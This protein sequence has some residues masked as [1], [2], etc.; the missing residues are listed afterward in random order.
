[1]TTNYEDAPLE[2]FSG[3]SV[4]ALYYAVLY[5]GDGPNVCSS[6]PLTWETA[7]EFNYGPMD[8][9][10]AGWYGMY[11]TLTHQVMQLEASIGK[12]QESW[13][14]Q[15]SQVYFDEANKA[16]ESMKEAQEKALG[17]ARAW[18]ELSSAAAFAYYGVVGQK[19]A[20]D[21]HRKNKQDE[22]DQ[23]KKDDDWY[24]PFDGADEPDWDEERAPF[25]E[26]ARRAVSYGSR[27]ISRIYVEDVWAPASYTPPPDPGGDSSIP[28]PGG[29]NDGGSGTPGSPGYPGGPGAPGYP[30]GPPSGTLPP[31]GSGPDLQGPIP[32]PMPPPNFP[33]PTLPTPTPTPTP[34][35]PPTLPPPTVPPPGLPKPPPGLPKPPPSL[36]KPPPVTPKPPPGLPRPT[37]TP[38]P[39]PKPPPNL[40]KPPPPSTGPTPRPPGRTVPPVI[41]PRP[42]GPGFNNTP[43]PPPVRNIQPPVIGPRSPMPGTGGKP[44]PGGPGGP[45]RGMPVPANRPPGVPQG[46]NSKSKPGGAPPARTGPMPGVRGGPKNRP[47][48]QRPGQRVPVDMRPTRFS[49]SNLPVPPTSRA[50]QPAPGVRAPKVKSGGDQLNRGVIRGAKAGKLSGTFQDNYGA[51]PGRT[52]VVKRRDD[53]E[54]VESTYEEQ[55]FTVDQNVVPGVIR[56]VSGQRPK[57]QAPSLGG[58]NAAFDDDDDW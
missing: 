31:P 40:P 52:G 55:V 18:D 50:T 47:S 41:G 25:D 32:P 13:N 28:D 17:N 27:E 48:Q 24:N 46:F 34:L 39:T 54:G 37:P 4:D 49:K 35:P 3:M 19:I 38:T 11:Q 14:S 16:L 5:D 42:G 21:E 22:Y 26:E 44:V 1:M 29:W 45:G 43:K 36:P 9:Q 57:K 7:Q 12:A 33:P 23:A 56:G 53:E 15:A 6:E 2:E 58:G 8:D 20:W 30:G 10:A 51:R